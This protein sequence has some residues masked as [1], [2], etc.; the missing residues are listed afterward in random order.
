MSPILISTQPVGNLEKTVFGNNFQTKLGEVRS[1]NIDKYVSKYKL[2]FLFSI[3]YRKF[4][5][6]RW[7]SVFWWQC[8]PLALFIGWGKSHCY[9]FVEDSCTFHACSEGFCHYLPPLLNW[10]GKKL[11]LNKYTSTTCL[12]LNLTQAYALN[13]MAQ[14]VHGAGR[15]LKGTV[16]QTSKFC[17][18][19][20]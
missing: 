1:V 13:K 9:Q 3:R 17:I 18:Y 6:P 2:T 20:I 8:L 7:F 15:Q 14:E 10:A 4:C 19:D 5:V 16:R 12:Q 11:F